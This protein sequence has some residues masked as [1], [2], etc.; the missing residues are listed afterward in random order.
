LLPQSLGVKGSL[1]LLAA[2]ELLEAELNRLNML[3]K[4]N[5]LEIG[6]NSSRGNLYKRSLTNTAAS[7]LQALTA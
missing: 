5:V 7:S 2:G 1:P 3:A 6:R 4:C